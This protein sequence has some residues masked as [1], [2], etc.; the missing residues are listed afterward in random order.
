[1]SEKMTKARAK[2]KDYLERLD[3]FTDQWAQMVGWREQLDMLA[4]MSTGFA[5]PRRINGPGGPE[6]RMLIL[7]QRNLID[8]WVRQAYLEGTMN[9]MGKKLTPAGRAALASTR[10]EP[11][12]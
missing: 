12:P 10:K 8:R 2:P 5:G 4:S 9:G 6:L 3:E 1:M 11:A 7:R